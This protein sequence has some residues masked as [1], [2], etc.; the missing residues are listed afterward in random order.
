MTVPATGAPTVAVSMFRGYPALQLGGRWLQ[1]W[2]HFSHPHPDKDLG[3]PGGAAA[4]GGRRSGSCRPAGVMGNVPP[5]L[6]GV[7]ACLCLNF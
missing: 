3:D 7:R 1:H 6:L 5:F 2:K 4:S